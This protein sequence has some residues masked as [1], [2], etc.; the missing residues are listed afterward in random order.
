ME[1]IGNIKKQ[2]NEIDKIIRDTRELQKEINTINGQIDRQFAVTD[3]LLF[4]VPLLC[5]ILHTN[6]SFV[7]SIT[8]S[9]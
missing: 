9:I 3:D 7:I 4:K 8:I 6:F 1:I 5:S 2:K